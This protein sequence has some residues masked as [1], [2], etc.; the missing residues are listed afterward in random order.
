MTYICSHQCGSLYFVPYKLRAL[1]P[2]QL[3][4]AYKLIAQ[5][6]NIYNEQRQN[7]PLVTDE[8]DQV[9]D[10]GKIYLSFYRNLWNMY[11][12]NLVKKTH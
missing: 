9:Q 2:A 11:T 12:S 7:Q 6:A 8:P 4:M 1:V 10:L 3:P 5:A